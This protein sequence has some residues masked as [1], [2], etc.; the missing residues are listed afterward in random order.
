MCRLRLRSSCFIDLL[1]VIL[2]RLEHKVSAAVVVPFVSSLFITL[3]SYCRSWICRMVCTGVRRVA[4]SLYKV[5][6]SFPSPR[7][8]RS[9]F[10]S[11]IIR[12]CYCDDCVFL[13][14]NGNFNASKPMG[15]KA[16]M[17]R[18]VS[19]RSTQTCVRGGKVPS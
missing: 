9:C 1:C 7:V 6:W 10:R 14:I 4:A 13:L 5:Q 11:C 8:R 16:K 19:C 12:W 15:V 17:V 2:R 18:G 3:V